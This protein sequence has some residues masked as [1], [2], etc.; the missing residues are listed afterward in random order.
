MFKRRG[1]RRRRKKKYLDILKIDS[2]ELVFVHTGHKVQRI[3]LLWDDIL[4]LKS[5]CAERN[6]EIDEKRPPDGEIN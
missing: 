5:L 6:T 1:G 2:D 3:L 4:E